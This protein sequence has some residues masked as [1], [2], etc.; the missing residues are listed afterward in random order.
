[1]SLYLFI[2]CIFMLSVSIKVT[3]CSYHVTCVFQ[4][5]STLN[6]CLNV[7]KLL[8]L[9][10]HKI[11][12]LSDC[13]WIQTQNHLVHKQ[14]LNHLAKLAKWLSFVLWVLIC[15]VD[16]T[17]CYY[18]VTYTFQSESTLYSCLNVK[19]L[20]AQSRH[21]IRRWSDCNWTQTQNHSVLKPTL[22]NQHWVFV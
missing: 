4:S 22:L 17:V 7:K 16:L 8:A 10:R 3:V 11:W 13:N 2:F 1:M 20:F 6:S 21:E 12:S 9:N 19:E 14:T 18:H 5:E 15:M